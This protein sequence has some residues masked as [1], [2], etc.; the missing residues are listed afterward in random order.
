MPV[1]AFVRRAAAPLIYRRPVSGLQP[2][3]LYLYLDALFARRGMRGPVIEIGC[4]LCG[5]AAI[6]A[7]F[8]RQIGST[9][10]YVCIDTFGGFVDAHAGADQAIG[11]RPSNRAMFRGNSLT[12]ASSLVR[13][14]GAADIIQLRQA[15]I[16][17]VEP[18]SLPAEISVCLIDVDLKRPVFDALEAVCD[19]VAPGGIVLVDDCPENTSWVGARAGYSEWVRSRGL[20]EVY[21]YGFGVVE[22]APAPG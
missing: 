12:L 7:R 15:D 5:T 8:L 9:R 22:K 4:H 13:R 14:Y 10:E 20:P 19:R 2:A 16:S 17:E 3:R 1:P 11:M 6:A 21:R 18:S